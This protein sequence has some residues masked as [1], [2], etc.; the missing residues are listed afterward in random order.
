MTLLSYGY[1]KFLL[2]EENSSDDAVYSQKTVHM[3]YPDIHVFCRPLEAR[4]IIT[5][6]GISVNVLIYEL[7]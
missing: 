7:S 2:C 3:P 6:Y 4:H 5:L 1:L